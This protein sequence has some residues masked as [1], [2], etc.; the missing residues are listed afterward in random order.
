MIKTIN[1][2]FSKIT[3]F[4]RAQELEGIKANKMNV[5]DKELNYLAWV[6][7]NNNKKNLTTLSEELGVKKGT[8]SNN[9]KLLLDKELLVRKI[10]P[11]DKRKVL[12]TPTE[13]GQ[14]YIKLHKK[15]HA[16]IQKRLLSLLSEE[17][18]NVLTELGIRISTSISN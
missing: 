1:K 2:A 16:K 8:L 18:L 10:D 13:K 14:E 17:E 9:I 15:F 6:A 3:Y 5:S 7:D 12:L 11:I 4:I